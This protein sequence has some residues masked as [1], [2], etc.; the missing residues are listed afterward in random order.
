MASFVI[1]FFLLGII[2]I[3]S[4]VV[5]VRELMT[6]FF[7]NELFVGIVL[8]VWLLGTGFGS[9]LILKLSPGLK[10]K[11]LCF[12]S[13][14]LLCL[15]LPILILL[16]RCFVG[17]TLLPG[18]VPSF[19]QSL[20]FT[21]L[22]LF[23]FCFL[24]G[25]LFS[26]GT[27]T[28]AKKDLAFLVS[29]AYF[30]ETIGFAIGG[31]LFNFL[32]VSSAFPLPKNF[33]R[34][35]LKFRYPNLVEITN[36]RYG[37]IVVTKTG[38]QFNFYESGTLLGPSEDREGSEY[39]IHTI[40]AFHQ[41]PKNVLFIGGGLNGP[42][43]EILKYKSLEKIDYI[44]LDP[45][46]VEIQ[47]KY[48]P[49]DLA[50]ILENPKVNIHL[51]DARKYLKLA[52]KK[53]DIIILSLPNP[54]TALL[55]RFYTQECFQEAKR[56]LTSG[57][58]L[59]FTLDVPVDY[60]SE[61]ARGLIASIDKTIKSVF[62][63][64]LF[65]PGETSILFLSS[66]T[67]LP[68]KEKLVT[69]KVETNYFTPDYLFYLL[70]SQKIDQ[71]KALLAKE[72][73][74]IN[75]DFHPTAYFLQTAFWQTTQS[76]K[77]A[78]IFKG[79]E[80]INWL[81]LALS[82]LSILFFL[83]TKLSSPI[84]TMGIAS[85]TLMTIEVLIIF[86]FQSKLGYLFSKIALIFTIILLS[87]GIGNLVGTKIKAAKKGLYLFKI[88]IILYLLIFFPTIKNLPQEPIFYLLGEIIGLLVGTVF[89]LTNRVYFKASNY[90]SSSEG[91]EATELR[92]SRQARTVI[93]SEKV[94]VLY[95]A[96]LFGAFFGAIFP[97][98]FFIPI[99]GVQKT[100]I[101]LVAFSLFT[102]K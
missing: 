6:A 4:Q 98:I 64:T 26:F 71:I 9:L 21:F 86:L 12:L 40:F 65:L 13:E 94:G 79:T 14:I 24:L 45:K 23:P 46:L 93:D 52:Q 15:L 91:A 51:L 27:K 44:E 32:F 62:S 41:D 88:L 75:T 95:S 10:S 83:K 60:L 100:I 80:K 18:E 11:K 61:E 84:L 3:I 101:F 28:W 35:S 70:S 43:F 47:V 50:K 57:G 55:N 2:S 5:I 73:P 1:Y 102:L 89:P 31:I 63:H 87:M 53:Y 72:E 77:L 33:N 39:F 97:S 42:L 74:K 82:A 78:K 36:S 48:L 54:S 69:H 59:S 37:N 8:G 17:V 19:S 7:G 92:S 81:I 29:R 38:N 49:A 30:F 25:G 16:I 99:F 68:S 76:F 34:L 56:L 96:D 20:I 85:F 22:I 90:Y 66:A 58:V 67:T